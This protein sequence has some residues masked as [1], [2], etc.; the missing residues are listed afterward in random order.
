MR[1][2]W[3]RLAAKAFAVLTLGLGVGYLVGG[4]AFVMIGPSG[5]TFGSPFGHIAEVIGLGAGCLSASLM[6]F[7]ML[8]TSSPKDPGKP[9]GPPSE[10]E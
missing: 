2:D 8:Q 6:T 1:F 4:V 5:N 3:P 9:G 7:I 10:L